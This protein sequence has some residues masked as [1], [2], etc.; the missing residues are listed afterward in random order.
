MC[1][2]RLDSTRLDL[3]FRRPE[4]WRAVGAAPAACAACG[5]TMQWHSTRRAGVLWR[6]LVHSCALSCT[7]VLS[8]LAM[9]VAGLA[10]WLRL[11]RL[12]RLNVLRVFAVCGTHLP[13]VLLRSTWLGLTTRGLLDLDRNSL[14]SQAEIQPAARSTPLF[15]AG[16]S[17]LF[18]VFLFRN[19]GTHRSGF[20]TCT[21]TYG[22][23]VARATSETSKR[24]LGFKKK[25]TI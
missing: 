9:A 24:I 23:N 21:I 11:L 8:C 18:T 16:F 13:A 25:G 22:P 12:L 6:A 5:V 15:S 7:L 3:T 2:S 14:S 19:T 10:L 20:L 4:G 17:L 1:V